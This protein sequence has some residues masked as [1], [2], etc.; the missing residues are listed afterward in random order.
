MIP[1]SVL[2]PWPYFP[3]VSAVRFALAADQCLEFRQAL[4]SPWCPMAWVLTLEPG[5]MWLVPVAAP[6]RKLLD[7]LV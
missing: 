6:G 2:G 5:N 1:R 4:E 7:Q 3:A